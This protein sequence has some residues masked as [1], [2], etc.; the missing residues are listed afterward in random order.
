MALLTAACVFGVVAGVVLLYAGVRS[1]LRTTAAR[2]LAALPVAAEQTV[3]I[4]KPGEIVLALR[5]RLF[6]QRFRGVSFALRDARTHVPVPGTPIVVRS[7]R[8]T[9]A[10]RV[11]LAVH[12]FAI[13]HP[14]AFVLSASGLAPGT[15]YTEARLVLERPQGAAIVLHVLWLVGAALLAVLALVFGLLSAGGA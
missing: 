1:L 13:P 2:E 12:R 6:S 15:D 10:G 9:L 11:T 5:D 7:G 14:G 4:A 8:T 3:A